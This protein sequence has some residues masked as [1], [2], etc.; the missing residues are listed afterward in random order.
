MG[1]LQLRSK[2]R[3]KQFKRFLR[4]RVGAGSCL[5]QRNLSAIC[6]NRWSRHDR[7][8]GCAKKLY[9]S[10]IMDLYNGEIVSYEK[11]ESPTPRMFLGPC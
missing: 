11:S 3:A 1:E 9:L 5:F 10:P 8:G 6:W 4:N 2:A 7:A